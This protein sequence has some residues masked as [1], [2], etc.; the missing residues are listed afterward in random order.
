M[1]KAMIYILAFT[2]AFSALLSGC[3]EIRGRG[4]DKTAPTET[5]E[6]TILPE[7][8]MPDPADGEVRDS[9]GIITD[10]DSGNGKAEAPAAPD[11]TVKP[12]TGTGKLSTGTKA[13]GKSAGAKQ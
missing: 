13:A 2:L 10:G 5:P 3:G 9:D 8:M 6:A 4:G 1:K 11:S 12:E 7:T